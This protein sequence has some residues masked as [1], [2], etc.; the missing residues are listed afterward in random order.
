MKQKILVLIS[1]EL[2][3]RNYI[4]TNAF[5]LLKNQFKCKFLINSRLIKSF[6]YKKNS[7][8]QRK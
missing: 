8:L 7:D 6:K 4:N 2:I 3:I 5:N 1:N